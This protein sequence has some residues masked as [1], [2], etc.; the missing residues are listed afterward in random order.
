MQEPQFLD[1]GIQ[2]YKKRFGELPS[3]ASFCVQHKT[4]QSSDIEGVISYCIDS[5]CA[6]VFGDPLTSEESKILLA[7]AFHVWCKQEGLEVMYLLVSEEFAQNMIRE[8]RGCFLEVAEEFFLNPASEPTKGRK[9]RGL[10]GKLKH[11]EEAQ[12][13]FQEY[14][15]NDLRLEKELQAISDDWIKRRKGPQI[16]MASGEL[17]KEK[18]GMRW[19]YALQGT[20]IVGVLLL[21]TLSSQ[22]NAIVRR[23][24]IIEEAPEGTSEYLI[25]TTWEQLQKEG[26]TRYSLSFAQKG[27]VNKMGGFS[28]LMKQVI[29]CIFKCINAVFHLSHR[30]EYW[31]K[32]QPEE[33]S[34]FLLANKKRLS[35]RHAKA[36]IH[37]FH[38]HLQNKK[39]PP[40]V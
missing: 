7:K 31:V 8:E 15:G 16:Y 11:A 6:V 34:L 40:R 5:K 39:P 9:G 24:P 14:R 17:F 33:R 4:F 25:Y 26:I 22:T 29:R 19:F 28:F 12:L 20:K 38:M 32:F 18:S 21:E 27:H 23:V 30:R 3:T 10:R 2:N 36:L 37:V 13:S 35:L 1:E